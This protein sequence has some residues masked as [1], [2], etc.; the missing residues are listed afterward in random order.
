MT[1][2]KQI[3]HERTDRVGQTVLERHVH[4]VASQKLPYPAL[5][6]SAVNIITRLPWLFIILTPPKERAKG[7]F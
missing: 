5:G 7:K 3:L 6:S 1:S 2:Q 4:P